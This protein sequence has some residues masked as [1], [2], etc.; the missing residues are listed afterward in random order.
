MSYSNFSVL[1]EVRQGSVCPVPA[2]TLQLKAD[3]C[4]CLTPLTQL[5]MVVGSTTDV[6]LFLLLFSVVTGRALCPWSDHAEY[7][8][9]VC[10]SLSL[11]MPGGMVVSRTPD[12]S[13]L[14]F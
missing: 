13:W 9:Q 8:G 2:K 4:V 3:L 14:Y 11:P 1:H 12:V 10:W 7:G 6:F 5:G